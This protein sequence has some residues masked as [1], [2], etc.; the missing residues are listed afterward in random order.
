MTSKEKFR[1]SIENNQLKRKLKQAVAENVRLDH[2][3]REL[4]KFAMERDQLKKSS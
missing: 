3:Y 2:E 4:A 1:L